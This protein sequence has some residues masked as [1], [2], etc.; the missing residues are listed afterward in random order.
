ME[1]EKDVEQV[2][3]ETTS[4]DETTDVE[5]SEQEESEN[6]EQEDKRS[7]EE[8]EKELNETRSKL[9]KA[10]TLLIKKKKAD[11]EAKTVS[12]ISEATIARLENRGVM[13]TEDQDYIIRFAK[14]EGISPIEALENDIVKD[15]LAYNEKERKSSQAGSGVNNRQVDQGDELTAW[16]REYK[17][18]GKLPE[19]RP[20]LIVKILRAV[21]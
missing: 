11:K 15:R 12:D 13:N 4:E 10:E 20:D 17:K 16:V 1:N 5:T 18:S 7:V 3:E 9:K 19:N 21:K 2:E 6:T 8:I 14:A